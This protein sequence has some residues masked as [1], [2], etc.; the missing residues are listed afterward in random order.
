MLALTTQSITATSTAAASVSCS[1]SLEY[2]KVAS[3][4]HVLSGLEFAQA[5]QICLSRCHCS[6]CCCRP[7]KVGRVSSFLLNTC[8]RDPN[9]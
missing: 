2:N 4:V 6:C 8:F 9:I 1:W 3:S 5:E 7:Q